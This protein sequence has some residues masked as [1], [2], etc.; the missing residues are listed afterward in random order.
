MLQYV[1]GKEVQHEFVPN[2]S[3]VRIQSNYY[4]QREVTDKCCTLCTGTQLTQRRLI[5]PNDNNSC[6]RSTVERGCFFI[7]NLF[8]FKNLKIGTLPYRCQVNSMKLTV[9]SAKVAPSAIF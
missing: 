2:Y 6:Y 4:G 7:L 9:F 3:P 1:A 8:Y 5:N